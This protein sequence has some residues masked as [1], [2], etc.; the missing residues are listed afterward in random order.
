[1]RIAN[2]NSNVNVPTA[3][4]NVTVSVSGNSNI[5]TVTGTGVNVSGYI[6]ATGNVSAGTNYLI[7]NGYY[8]TGVDKLTVG[9]ADGANYIANGTSNIDTPVLNGNITVGIG[10]TSNT[11]IFTST[12]VN[13]AGYIT[14]SAG[15]GSSNGIIFP[16]NPG[17]GTLDV[18]SIKYYAVTGEQT[19]LELSVQNDGIGASRDDLYFS[20]AGYTV[21]NNSIEATSTTDAPFQ[22]IGGVGIAKKLY[23]GGNVTA[24]Y[25]IGNGAYLTGVDLLTVGNADVANSIANGTSNINTPILNGNITV[26][27]GGTSNTVIFT[28]TG[29]NVAG[30]ITATGNVTGNFIKGNGY[31]LTGVDTSNVALRIA[32]GTSNINIPVTNGNITLGVA[33]TSNV[34]VVTSTGVNIAGYANL[35]SGNLTT[36]GNV[37][38]GYFIGNGSQLTGLTSLAVANAN[39]ANYAG[40]VINSSQSN[41][42]SLGTLISLSVTG[43]TITGAANVTSTASS[44]ST[45]SGALVVGGGVGIG[46]NLYVGGN[47]SI[48]GTTTIINSTTVSINDVNIVL[49]NNATNSTEANGAGIT[50]NGAAASMNYIAGTNSF[51]FS[52]KLIATGDSNLGNSVT[53]NY[54]LGDGGLLSNLS[55]PTSIST[56]EVNTGTYYVKLSNVRSGTAGTYAN[57]NFTYDA[58]TG[59]LSAGSLSLTGNLTSLNANL[60]NAIRGNYFIGNG[61]LLTGLTGANIIGTVANANYS[62]YSGTVLTNAQPNITSVGLLSNLIVGNVTSNTTFGNGTINLTGNVTASYYFGNGSQLTGISSAGNANVSAQQALTVATTGTYYMLFGNVATGN[63]YVFSNANVQFD[64]NVGNLIST[65]LTGTIQTTTQPNIASIGN[66]TS[67]HSTLGNVIALTGNTIYLNGST[68]AAIQTPIVNLGAGANS[69]SL[70]SNDGKDRGLTL[71]YYNS[72]TI[73]AFMGWKNANSEFVF[74]SSATVPSNGNATI[75]TLGNIRAG[76]A[77]LGNLASAT[78]F[79]G[80]L[81]TGAQPNI[82]SLG[83]LS[84]LAVTGNITS[85]NASLGNAVN[86]N[87]FIG[88]G[89]L[90]TGIGAPY[91]ILYGNSNVSIPSANAN[92]TV[93]VN[94]TS[95]V[96]VISNNKMVVSGNVEATYFKGDGSLL[97]GLATGA[98]IINGNSSIYVDANSNVRV[99][100]NGVSNVLVVSSTGTTITGTINT[101]NITA[102]G[103]IN[104]TTSSN[105]SLG[106]VANIKITGGSSGQYLKTDGAG[107]LSWAAAAGGSGGSSLTYTTGTNPPATGNVLGDQW[108]NTTTSVLYEYISD[109]TSSYWVDISGSTTTTNLPTTL[110]LTKISITGGISGQVVSTDG[111]GN[112]T[113]ANLT[114][115]YSGNSNVV[116]TANS[117]VN[118]SSNGVANVLTVTSTGANLLS[119]GTA[120]LGNLVTA[121]YVA[122]TLT[123]GAQPNI[124]SVGSLTGLT[125]T[126]ATTFALSSDVLLTKS[127]ATG[128]VA[129]DLNTGAIFYHTSPAANFTANFTNVPTTDNRVLTVTLIISQGATPYMPNAVAIES[130]SQTIKWIAGGV[131]PTG[132]ANKND[133]VSFTLIRTGST[134]IV[135]G[136]STFYG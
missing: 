5:V 86:A 120:N 64:S 51:T 49:A 8:I 40:N 44:T 66:A 117:N 58:A 104:F 9:N 19:R 73:N 79:T 88:D 136:Q 118:I 38:A 84:S 103:N 83:T 13:V 33:G 57:A 7:G 22:V 54:F 43:T 116:V 85:G 124:T 45:T 89:S 97:T 78:Y 95:N 34:A 87:Y 108:F 115:I 2:G 63:T 67:N 65:Y 6:T 29:V 112:L 61:S 55:T 46:G 27:I 36:T 47:L 31:Y 41:I 4:G 69:A 100:S 14:P 129:H 76:N 128:V 133:V 106:A 102:N 77:N 109:G 119:T 125:V 35:G 30:Y 91:N 134:W 1:M 123:T 53:S 114:Q 94:N 92:V 135:F 96:V 121:N 28:S 11:V 24:P 81:T 74:A 98:S 17:G 110:D 101:A 68:A 52:H 80:T 48:A 32:N 113:L 99:S 10:G 107:N 90:L 39:Y 56:T 127:G 72:G 23:V 59:I 75:N 20:A 18:A 111:A 93:S 71:S 62:T 12:G 26:G 70:G 37:T 50:I 132:T 60:G 122:G 131:A 25:F 82:T 42:T 130:I 15:N 3:N 126:G 105:V 21:V 16:A